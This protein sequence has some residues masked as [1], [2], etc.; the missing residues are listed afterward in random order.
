VIGGRLD[1]F[2]LAGQSNMA[3]RGLVQACD[4]RVNPRVV[5]LDR[6]GAWAPAADPI[7]FDKPI[8]GVG[9]GLTFG[10][11]MARRDPQAC[12][13]LIPCAVGG[14]DLASWTPGTV[15]HET[16]SRPY[17]D[18]VD[19]ARLSMADGTLRATLWHQ[20]ETDALGEG[21]DAGRCEERLV[22]LIAA[23]R[24]DLHAPGLLFLVDT[25]GD[26]LDQ[27]Y[28]ARER[29]NEALRHIPERV[30][31]TACVEASGLQAMDDGVHFDPPSARELGRRYA[32]AFLRLLEEDR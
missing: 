12:I 5:C 21:D 13:G 20:G 2:L 3:G 7:H 22:I 19:R 29:I 17:D 9:P 31:R 15:W 23:L 6:S 24:A 8:A 28:L 18:A 26:F 11:I 25:L 30:A 16:G 14:S 10:R 1:L 32:R 4:R 27:T